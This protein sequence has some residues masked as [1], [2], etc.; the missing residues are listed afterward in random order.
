MK[1]TYADIVELLAGN[2]DL[3]IDGWQYKVNERGCDGFETTRKLLLTDEF[4][5]QVQ[6]AVDYLTAHPLTGKTLS[7]Q[8]ARVIVAATPPGRD[9]YAPHGAVIAAAVLLEYSVRRVL[10]AP[11]CWIERR[12]IRE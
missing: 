5:S 1:I 4:L 8:V 6:L 10:D 12:Q 2:P 9:G 3:T 7:N 11:T